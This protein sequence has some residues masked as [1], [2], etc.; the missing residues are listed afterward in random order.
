MVLNFK[1]FRWVHC[2][3]LLKIQVYFNF[4]KFVP[5]SYFLSLLFLTLT[6]KVFNSHQIKLLIDFIN[7]F[8]IILT[9]FS[10][11][12]TLR[13]KLLILRLYLLREIV[14]LIISWVFNFHEKD[15][16]L[17][18]LML[19]FHLWVNQLD[20]QKHLILKFKLLKKI[21]Q[22]KVFSFLMIKMQLILQ[23]LKL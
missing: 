13:S 19:K 4:L 15:F 11:L 5:L 16:K 3:N 12:L 6:C 20:Q 21:Q 17:Y 8:V 9:Y 18:L 7:A 14:I 2:F 1:P 22:I 10:L 23:A